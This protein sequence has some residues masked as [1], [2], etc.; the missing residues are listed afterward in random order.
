[1]RKSVAINEEVAP[2]D[3]HTRRELSTTL[4]AFGRVQ[5]QAG[6]NVEACRDFRRAATMTDTLLAEHALASMTARMQDDRRW[7]EKALAGCGSDP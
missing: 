7:L 2:L 1:L 4:S 5:R 6:M 3:A